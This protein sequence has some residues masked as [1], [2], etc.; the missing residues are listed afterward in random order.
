MEESIDSKLVVY[1]YTQFYLVSPKV[2][3]YVDGDLAGEVGKKG[4]LEIPITQT[5]EV[6]FICGSRIE[7][8]TAEYGK[9]TKVE[10]AWNR[11]TGQLILNTLE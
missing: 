3:V 7:G 8:L 6:A 10:L 2:S 11:T 5:S 1:G 9:T 4:F